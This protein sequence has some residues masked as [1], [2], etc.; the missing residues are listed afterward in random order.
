MILLGKKNEMMKFE[1]KWI[2]LG[3]VKFNDVT[4]SQKDRHCTCFLT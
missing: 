2:A 1:R 4:Q 3:S